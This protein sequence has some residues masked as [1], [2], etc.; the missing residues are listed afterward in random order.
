VGDLVHRLT[1]D[2]ALGDARAPDGRHGHQLIRVADEHAPRLLVALGRELDLLGDVHLHDLL[3]QRELAALLLGPA[4]TAELMGVH[5]VL[6]DELF[7]GGPFVDRGDD[8]LGPEQADPRLL[9]LRHVRQVQA[10][11][12][13]EVAHPVDQ[14]SGGVGV[15]GELPDDVVGPQEPQLVGADDLRAAFAAPRGELR[16]GGVGRVRVEDQHLGVGVVLPVQRQVPGEHRSLDLLVAKRR[17]GDAVGQ[18]GGRLPGPLPHGLGRVVHQHEQHR[19]HVRGRQRHEA[20]GR[21]HSQRDRGLGVDVLA[22]LVGQ[23]IGR[24]GARG[25]LGLDLGRALV[26]HGGF[27]RR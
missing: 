24:D 1:V 20:L 10:V 18:V 17:G 9:H 25:H 3:G 26:T 12:H 5:A 14:R 7:G 11:A 23:K 16:D 15:L 8:H 6:G 21:H 22:H 27:S 13:R 2:L 19:H 4:A